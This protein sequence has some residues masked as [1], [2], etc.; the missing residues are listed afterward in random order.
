MA[1]DRNDKRN[2]NIPDNDRVAS[3]KDTSAQ[4]TEEGRVIVNNDVARAVYRDLFSTRT[5]AWYTSRLRLGLRLVF[6]ERERAPMSSLH[7][8]ALHVAAQYRIA[9]ENRNDGKKG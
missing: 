1:G 8:Q 5:W 3:S 7:E 9:Y 6:D 4:Y 2:T